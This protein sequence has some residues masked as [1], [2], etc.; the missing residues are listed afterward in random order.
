MVGTGFPFPTTLSSSGLVESG[1]TGASYVS[2]S[3]RIYTWEAGSLKPTWYDPRNGWTGTSF[4]FEPTKGYIV[5][6]TP[7][8][9]GFDWSQPRPEM[10]S[11]GFQAQ[12]AVMGG[13]ERMS[14]PLPD[15]SKQPWGE[16]P[17]PEVDKAKKKDKSKQKTGGKKSKNGRVAK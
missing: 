7:G 13:L 16:G 1:L 6:I 8:H 3:D 14:L 17:P 11:E 10:Y 12:V 9:E 2:T 4:G 5:F 15:F